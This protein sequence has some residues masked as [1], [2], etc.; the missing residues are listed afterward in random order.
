VAQTSWVDVCESE[1]SPCF[2]QVEENELG[3][4]CGLDY[5][6]RFVRNARLVAARVI[7]GAKAAM[8]SSH[9]LHQF[10]V[11]SVTKT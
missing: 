7:V 6:F 9:V 4:F 1:P 5:Q 10:A 11:L 3:V 8:T 2:G